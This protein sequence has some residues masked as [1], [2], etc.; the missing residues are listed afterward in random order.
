M[1][2]KDT[3]DHIRYINDHLV[4][5]TDLMK[6]IAEALDQDQKAIQ[7]APHEGQIL[8]TLVKMSKPK[9][10]VE[11]GTL[12]G[13]SACWFLKAMESESHLFTVEYDEENHKKAKNFLKSH[14][15][16]QSVECILSSGL[17]FLKSWPEEKSIDFLFLD[18]DKGGYLDYLELAKSHMKSGSVVVADN[19]FLFDHVLSDTPP[20]DYSKNTWS[21]MRE[22]NKILSGSTGEFFGIMI[23]TKQGMTVGVKV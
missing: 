21:K 5:E 23:P 22:L 11:I 2:S 20:K 3:S 18:A 1:K 7:V 9:N 16:S 4:L 12:Y 13:Y 6:E 14:D 17:E 15:R 10:L 8:S 19:S